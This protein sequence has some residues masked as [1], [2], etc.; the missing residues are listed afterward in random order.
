MGKPSQRRIVRRI[1]LERFLSEISVH[2]SPRVGLE[3]YTLSESAA[4]T[5]LRLSAYTFDDIV[6][7]TVLDL[8]CGTGRLALGAAFLEAKE[9]TGVDIDRTAIDTALESSQRVKVT[10]PPQWII[11]DVDAI[12][13]RFDTV[14]QNP[15]FGVQKRGA[16]R[17]FLA[18]ALQV[19]KTVYSLHNHPKA[20]TTL[21][22]HLKKCGEQILQVPVSPFIRSF[23]E[24]LDGRIIAV[25]ALLTTIPH[26]FFFHTKIRYD[27]VV[28]LYVIERES[29]D[30]SL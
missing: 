19:G 5:I 1:E 18:K 25:Y 10:N 27:L 23:V 29:K 28:D 22:K 3:Q 8:G 7:K 11:G 12:V 4:A 6:G 13:G 14:L 16:D 26:M 9:V 21:V 15:P 30:T 2:P 24:N 17:K 20:D